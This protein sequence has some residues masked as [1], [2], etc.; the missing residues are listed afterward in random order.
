MKTAIKIV[1]INFLLAQI[2]APLVIVIPYIFYLLSTSQ[3]VSQAAIMQTILIPAQLAGQFLMALYLW[4]AGYISKERSTWSPVSASYLG[5]SVLAILSCGVV[6]TAITELMKGIPNIME[7][8]FDIL[9][10]G[11]GGILAIA[12]IGPTVE[13]L[14]FRGAV[15][16][17]LLKQ[18]SPTKAIL[19]SSL[20]FAVFHLNPAQMLPAF[21]LGALLAWTYYKTA[22]LI[23]CILMHIVN[24]SLSVYL[25][26][27][28]PEA[29]SLGDIA[30]T[31]TYFI[32]VSAAAVILAGALLLMRRTSVAYPWKQETE[33]TN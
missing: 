29:E 22:S 25:I 15:L 31:S 9:S 1:L 7:Q 16:K 18:Y 8:A 12:I 19:I 17:A 5:L 14:V 4:K 13:E 30:G 20:L 24:N 32:I 26:A 6:V 27:R 10:S 11:W 33:P 3:P 28:Y 21:L 2:V 23:P